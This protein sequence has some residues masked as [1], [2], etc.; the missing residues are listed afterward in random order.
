M[1]GHAVDI[2]DYW[3][4]KQQLRES[5]Q[6]STAVLA[7]LEEGIVFCGADG[8]VREFNA[9]AERILGTTPDHLFGLGATTPPWRVVRDDGSP[10]SQSTRP[11]TITLRTGQPCLRV[12][13]GLEQP[14]GRVLWLEV[15]SQPLLSH[16]NNTPYGAVV[17]FTDITERRRHDTEREQELEEALTGLK[18]LRGLLPIC[19]SCKK[20][21]ADDG[22]WQPLETYYQPA[23]GGRLHPRPLPGLSGADRPDD[24]SRLRLLAGRG[25]QLLPLPQHCLVD[26]GPRARVIVKQELLDRSR[27][28]LPIFNELEIDQRL[29]VGLPNGVEPEN[30]RRGLI[31]PGEGVEDRR[32]D[33]EEAE[34]MS[35]SRGNPAGSSMPR[36]PIAGPI[37]PRPR[38]SRHAAP[39]SPRRSPA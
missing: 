14:D 9:T 28:H 13:L 17:S 36:I 23:L 31:G 30:V 6:R 22:V 1:I 7:A 32:Q 20:I 33:K 26:A 37:A 27:V 18:V 11:D 10:A 19:A 25:R 12:V 35:A 38:R 29:R 34:K 24:R 21:R 16:R 5:E 4:T 39:R 2:T 3:R 15:N 8:S